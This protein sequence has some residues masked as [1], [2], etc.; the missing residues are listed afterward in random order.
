MASAIS[1]QPS[2]TPHT[3]THDVH[4]TLV[5]HETRGL[6]P[7]GNAPRASAAC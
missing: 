4:R 3:A 7:A 6:V 2:V 5:R 1:I